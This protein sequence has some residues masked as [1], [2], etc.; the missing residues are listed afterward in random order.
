MKKIIIFLVLT[1]LM[2][3]KTTSYADNLFTLDQ[4]KGGIE[5]VSKDLRELHD[6][7]IKILEVSGYDLQHNVL[8][9]YFV[10]E[11]D[12]DFIKDNGYLRSGGKFGYIKK[13]T[14]AYDFFN[15]KWIQKKMEPAEAEYKFKIEDK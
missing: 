9:V 11:L 13:A 12:I 3:F 8:Y 5:S 7:K 14:Y 2:F 6:F 4:I 1:F 15:S 10:K